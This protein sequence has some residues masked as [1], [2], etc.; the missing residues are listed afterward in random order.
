MRKTLYLS[1]IAIGLNGASYGHTSAPPIQWLSTEKPEALSLNE[2]EQ[3]RK[4]KRLLIDKI[5][6]TLPRPASKSLMSRGLRVEWSR[7]ADLTQKTKAA[8]RFVAPKNDAEPLRIEMDLELL[9]PG[10]AKRVLAHETF[11]AAHFVVHQDEPAWLREGLAEIFAFEVAGA[12]D[13]IAVTDARTTPSTPLEADYDPNGKSLNSSHYGHSFLFF[14][15]LLHHCVST[16]EERLELIWKIAASTEGRFGQD[17]IDFALGSLRQT[18]KYCQDF[19]SV[20][21]EFETARIVNQS[22][23]DETNQSVDDR[24]LLLPTWNQLGYFAPEAATSA[25]LE[26]LVPSQPVVFEK[27]PL[28]LR[29]KSSHLNLPPGV[30]LYWIEMSGSFRRIRSST[31]PSGVT[32]GPNWKLLVLKAW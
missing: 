22:R 29:K 18:P 14:H 9:E 26:T 20:F 6:P 11:H 3:L 21:L 19:K 25:W 13:R 30:D 7:R 12:Y 1:L 28:F 10:A 32:L 8:G 31:R 23:F 15:Y 27:T 5:L 24:L 16:P 2:R 4:L 17:T